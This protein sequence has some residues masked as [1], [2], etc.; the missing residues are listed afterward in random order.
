[1][2]VVQEEEP[3]LAS[4]LHSSIIA[5]KTLE[6]SLAFILSNK[7]SSATLLPTNIM[8][9]I[10]AAYADDPVRSILPAVLRERFIYECFPGVKNTGYFCLCW[11]CVLNRFLT[12]AALVFILNEV[13]CISA[14]LV[15]PGSPRARCPA[16][17]DNRL[18]MY[19]EKSRFKRQFHADACG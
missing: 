6:D 19:L 16:A 12:L 18:C 14:S 10:A 3:V 4:H 7:L 11:D 8:Q 13:D 5:H 15:N 1:V 17:V 2:D 9:M